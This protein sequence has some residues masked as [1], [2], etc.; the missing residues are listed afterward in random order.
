MSLC[1]ETITPVTSWL[2]GTLAVMVMVVAV[3]VGD[4]S[5]MIARNGTVLKYI[6]IV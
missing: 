5:R 2:W 3:D 4:V 6:S 1:Q